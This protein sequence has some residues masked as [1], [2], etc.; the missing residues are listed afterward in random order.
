[1]T[2]F[3]HNNKNTLKKNTRTKKTLLSLALA[4]TVS[5]SSYAASTAVADDDWLHVQG[6]QILDAQGNNVW[7]TGANWF[8]FNT[9]E[10]VLHGLWSV[11]LETTI[12]AIAGR[13][14]N[15]LRVPISTE[16]LH[17]WQNGVSTIAQIN[18]HANPT[19]DGYHIRSF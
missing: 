16:L 19:L 9:S 8:G 18:S 10:R 1:M 14:I 6:N 15:L 5:F 13:G 3:Q 2:L 12:N 4:M 11:N 17:E 7:L